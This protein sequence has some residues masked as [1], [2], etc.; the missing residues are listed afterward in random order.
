MGDGQQRNLSACPKFKALTVEERLSE[1]QKHKA[2]FLLPPI[3]SLAYHL[4]E[5]E[6]VRVD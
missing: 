6:T 5:L 3:W 2:V 1:V 4:W